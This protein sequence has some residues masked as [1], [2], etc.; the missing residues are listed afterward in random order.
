MKGLQ[1]ALNSVVNSERVRAGRVNGKKL[2]CRES[3]RY[4]DAKHNIKGNVTRANSL[5]DAKSFSLISDAE[6]LELFGDLYP[7]TDRAFEAV[8]GVF[9]TDEGH[10]I[11]ELKADEVVDYDFIV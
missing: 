4:S 10:H 5:R 3:D 6:S 8:D 9:I 11:L 7:V 2:D 1:Q